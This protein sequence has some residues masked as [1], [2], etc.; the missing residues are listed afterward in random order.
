MEYSNFLILLVI[1]QFKHFVADYLLQGKY[2]LGKFKLVG[3]EMPLLAHSSVHMVMTYCIILFYLPRE[4]AASLAVADMAI[5]FIIDRLKVLLSRDYDKDKE[6]WW[7][8]G[9]DQMAHHFTHYL[10]VF[11]TLGLMET[12]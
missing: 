4:Y 6:F 10:I 12:L 3:W 5:H 11:I 8:L 9:A 2:T 1:F 7:C